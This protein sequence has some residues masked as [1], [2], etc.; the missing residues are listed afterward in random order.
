[1]IRKLHKGYSG[2][3]YL[4]SYTNYVLDHSPRHLPS[5]HFYS[6]GVS[7]NFASADFRK[8]KTYNFQKSESY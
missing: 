3:Q 7:S 2:V 1:M 8:I 5:H 6:T 4:L